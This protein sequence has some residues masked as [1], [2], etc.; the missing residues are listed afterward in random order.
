[1]YTLSKDVVAVRNK[2][3]G[4]RKKNMKVNY[5]NNVEETFVEHINIKFNTSNGCFLFGMI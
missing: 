4:K 2:S 3:K 5:K 1:M